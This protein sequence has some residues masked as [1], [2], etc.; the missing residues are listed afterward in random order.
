MEHA[1][2]ND[3]IERAPEFSNLLDRKSTEFEVL[4]IVLSLEIARMA[5]ARLADI[6]RGD[7]GMRFAK[8]I[9][10][11][12]RRAAAGHEDFQ[13]PALSLGRPSQIEM[14]AATLRI[15]VEIYGPD[16]RPVPDMASSR[17][18]RGHRQS[19]QAC[20]GFRQLGGNSIPAEIGVRGA[21]TSWKFASTAA[22]SRCGSLPP[23]RRGDPNS[24]RRRRWRAARP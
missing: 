6:D 16:W 18:S 17:R 2:A 5:Q 24:R 9:S 1:G 4:Q 8:R 7:S 23:A 19:C 13:V 20:V 22:P 3:Q 15:G 12:L 21:P 14:R 10:R 11:R